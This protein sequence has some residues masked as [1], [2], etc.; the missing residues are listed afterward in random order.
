MKG[1]FNWIMKTLKYVQSNKQDYA[2]LKTQIKIESTKFFG[3]PFPAHFLFVIP[4]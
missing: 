2:I 4:Y 3:L 1:N